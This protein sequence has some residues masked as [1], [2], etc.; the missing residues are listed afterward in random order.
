MRGRIDA[1]ASDRRI[2]GPML[3]VLAKG[4]AADAVVC[5][6]FSA[7]VL[8]PSVLLGPAQIL[9]GG[10]GVGMRAIDGRC[11]Q[12]GSGSKRPRG[13]LDG[14]PIPDAARVATPGLPSAALLLHATFGSAAI[15]AI[16][17]RSA[18]RCR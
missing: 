5:G 17:P 11:R 3:A 8:E 18:N 14:A 2:A 4:N 12:P 16:A 1:I 9:V 6:L 10:T 7:A 13:Y 15:G